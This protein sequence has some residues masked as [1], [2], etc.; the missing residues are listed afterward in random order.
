MPHASTWH[1]FV[2]AI[3]PFHPAVRVK[4]SGDTEPTVWEPWVI[5][6]SASYLETGTLGPV[7]FREVEWVEIDLTR[8]NVSGRLVESESIEWRESVLAALVSAGL[9]FPVLSNKIRVIAYDA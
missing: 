8:R 4:W 2:D 5:I 7:P 9:S 6:P 3:K 1:R